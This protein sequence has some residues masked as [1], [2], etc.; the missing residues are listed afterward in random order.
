MLKLPGRNDP[1]FCGSGLKYKKCCGNRFFIHPDSLIGRLIRLYR[2]LDS[3]ALKSGKLPCKAG[4]SQCCQGIMFGISTIEFDFIKYNLLDF[5]K[6]TLYRIEEWVIFTGNEI[7]RKVPEVF[8]NP[9]S[10]TPSS[11]N[12][13][14]YEILATYR[15]NVFFKVG[16]VRCPFLENDICLIYNYRPFRL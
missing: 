1:C 3:I 15:E 6:D 16:R 10:F 14:D 12:A 2:Y 8:K 7:M 9:E 4:C 13:A 11:V 5:P